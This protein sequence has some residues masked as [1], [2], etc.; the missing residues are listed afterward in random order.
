M[1]HS[2]EH[3]DGPR[4]GSSGEDRRAVDDLVTQTAVEASRAESNARRPD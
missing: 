1:G 3:R 2:A 4:S